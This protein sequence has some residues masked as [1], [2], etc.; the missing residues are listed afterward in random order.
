[1]SSQADPAPEVLIVVTGQLPD[2]AASRLRERFRVTQSASP[3][4]FL[5]RGQ[6]DPG[7][8][9]PPGVHVFSTP[10]V[11]EEVLRALDA[12]E[13]LFVAAWRLRWTGPKQRRGEGLDWDAPGFEPPR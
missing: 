5:G 9:P 6:P 13:A 11:P 4:V 12:R 8:P 7:W 3:R 10:D 2:E 1:M